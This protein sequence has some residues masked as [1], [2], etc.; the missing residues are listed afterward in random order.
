[1]FS[2]KKQIDMY[3]A[4]WTNRMGCLVVNLTALPYAFSM[5]A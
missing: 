3:M 4:L 5:S 2:Q 1:M